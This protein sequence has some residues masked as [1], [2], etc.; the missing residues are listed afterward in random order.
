[1]I[2]HVIMY[3]MN[4]LNNTIK[5]YAFFVICS[6]LL[7]VTSVAFAQTLPSGSD[8]HDAD[9]QALRA[10]LTRV[11]TTINEKKFDELKDYLDP[12]A[13]LIFE[14]AEVADGADA[15]VS[16]YKNLF[17]GNTAVLRDMKTSVAVTKPAEFYGNTAV[18]YG[19]ADDILTTLDGSSFSLRS[20]WSVT[21]EKENGQWK[22]VSLQFT[23]NVFNNPI[24]DYASTK[25]KAYGLI[26]LVIGFLVS[27]ILIVSAMKLKGKNK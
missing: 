26:G 9:H 15:A 14:N 19:T 27:G 24:L 7:G 21:L 8:G 16:F 5:K 1:M 17:V 20:L 22:V 3:H 13:N 10:M 6:A 12:Q 18:A 25:A 23:S 2:F 11:E 4:K